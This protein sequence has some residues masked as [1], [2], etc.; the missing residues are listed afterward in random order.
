M[1]IPS[2]H[3]NTPSNETRVSEYEENK[4]RS[5]Q[6]VNERNAAKNRAALKKRKQELVLE[7]HKLFQE[8]EKFEGNKS[9][10]KRAIKRKYKRKQ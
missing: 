2:M 6:A 8:K 1:A 4:Q 7:Y 10:Q 5:L 3:I 9:Y